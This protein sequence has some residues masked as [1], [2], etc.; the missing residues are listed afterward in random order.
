MTCIDVGS[1]LVQISGSRVLLTGATGGLGQ[2]IA[3][4]LHTR[5]A[6][7][8]LTGRRAEVLARLACELDARALAVDLAVPAEVDRLAAEAGEVDILIANAALPASGRL[9]TYTQRQ[10]DR[11]LNVNLRAPIALAHAASPGM[12]ARGR[13]HL[14]FVSSLSG[15]AAAPD[16][17]LYSATKFGLRGFALGLREDLRARGVGVSVV[18]PGFISDTGLRAN[19]DVDVRLPLG[20]GMR[21][22]EQVARG[23]VRAIERNR[24]EVEIAPLALRAGTAFASLAP[25]L[26]ARLARVMGSEKIAREVSASQREM[27]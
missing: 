9:D 21:T 20:A 22:S 15:K 13:G 19:M 2:A 6:E 14:L 4:A 17:S 8:I 23:V 16:S 26:A 3:R 1:Q 12:V 7:L 5:G 24:A 11:A 18:L 25:E 27:R 10:I